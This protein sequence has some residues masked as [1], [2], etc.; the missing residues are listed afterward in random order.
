MSIADSLD[1]ELFEPIS[2]RYLVALPISDCGFGELALVDEDHPA[3]NTSGF[4]IYT[5]SDTYFHTELACC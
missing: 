5:R 3:R 4:K 1:F 2:Q